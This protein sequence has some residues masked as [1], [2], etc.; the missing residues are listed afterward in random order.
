VAI[1]L[2]MHGGN[3]AL[4]FLFYH[5]MNFRLK[6]LIRVYKEIY[7]YDYEPTE[8]SV[9]LLLRKYKGRGERGY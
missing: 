4:K 1:A 6:K 9:K 7:E 8:R 3:V 5:D 2:Q